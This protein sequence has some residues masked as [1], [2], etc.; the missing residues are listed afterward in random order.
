MK[1]VNIIGAGLSGS[2]A[3]W[4]LASRGF[5]V[6]IFEMRDENRKTFAHRTDHFA[7]LV[8]SNSLRSDDVT[9]A[10][11]LL[12]QEMRMLNSLVMRSA[13]AN[14]I[15]AGTALAVDRE[16]FSKF[17]ENELLATRK[18]KI[19]RREISELPV[20]SDETWIIAT[21]PL[22]SDA[23]SQS[24]LKNSDEE[25]LAFFDA[26]API[27]FKDSIDFSKAWFQS[28]YDKGNGSDYVNCP[29]NRDQYY[30]FVNDLLAAEKTEFKDWEKDTPYFDGCLPIEVMAQRGV[31]TLRHGPMK[32]V[33]LTNPHFPRSPE[34]TPNKDRPEKAHGIIQLRQ[35]NKIGTLYNIV[36]FQTK[37]KYGD[38]Q[39]IFRKIPGLENA[40]FARFGGIHRN[41][42][43]NSPK[44]L[45][46]FLRFKKSPNILFAGQVTGVEGYVESAAMGL[47]AGIFVAKNFE[48][49]TPN[50]KTAIGSL[51]NHITLGHEGL[52]FQPM[53]VNFG[54]FENLEEKTKKTDRKA[55][56]S[57]RALSEL[58]IWKT[59]FEK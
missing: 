32:P 40:E 24:I 51:L 41:T 23:L 49:A 10:I 2:E 25:H 31:E 13:D 42:F 28:R 37:M 12:H 9:T 22:T 7:E 26:I 39:R 27:V 21:G 3:A 29:L 20:N 14:K 33:G 38:Q 59:S 46:Q 6:E 50:P 55:A 58:E 47:I 1:K 17:I 48:I 11:G 45:D 52:D 18:V 4:Q 43:I 16:G 36:G 35:D 5:E 19:S 15:P 56:Y 57:N 30:E 53:N 44:L 34:G 54:L 8:C